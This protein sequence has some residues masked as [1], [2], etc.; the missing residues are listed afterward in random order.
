MD[1]PNGPQTENP[2]EGVVREFVL[3]CATSVGFLDFVEI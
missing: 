3:I 2:A 1:G